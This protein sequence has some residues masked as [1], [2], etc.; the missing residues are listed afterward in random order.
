MLDEPRQEAGANSLSL[1]GV[2]DQDRKLGG[3]ASHGAAA[4]QRDDGGGGGGNQGEVL[5]LP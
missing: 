4:R 2:L 5:R 1:A 3:A